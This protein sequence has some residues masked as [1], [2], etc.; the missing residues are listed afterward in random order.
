MNTTVHIRL[1]DLGGKCDFGPTQGMLLLSAVSGM[2]F[3]VP[4]LKVRNLL[5]LSV[6]LHCIY[7]APKESLISV[8]HLVV[9]M[10]LGHVSRLLT[11]S[12]HIMLVVLRFFVFSVC[13]QTCPTINT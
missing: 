12:L 8:S 1:Q 2:T 3:T 9:R 5:E 11:S 7:A 13:L 6:R 10:W 4:C